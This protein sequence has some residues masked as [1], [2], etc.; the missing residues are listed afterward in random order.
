MINTTIHKG[1]FI[2][3]IISLCLCGILLGG[4]SIGANN[5]YCEAGKFERN[6]YY[7][8]N[9]GKKNYK[10]AGVCLN[11][12]KIIS[13]RQEVLEKSYQGYKEFEDE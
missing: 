9:T 3:K 1:R 6:L 13:H 8:F 2:L 5:S 10:N 11:A 12:Y 7:K 4:C